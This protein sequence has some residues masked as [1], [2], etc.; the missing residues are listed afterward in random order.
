VAV[1]HYPQQ[2]IEEVELFN[3][4]NKQDRDR[5]HPSNSKHRSSKQRSR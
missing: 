4:S 2:K 3:S 1:H 5:K